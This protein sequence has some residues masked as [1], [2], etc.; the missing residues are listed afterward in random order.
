MW[1]AFLTL[2]RKSVDKPP[3][4]GGRK[5][6]DSIPNIGPRESVCVELLDVVHCENVVRQIRDCIS[7]S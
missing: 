1:T 3:R 7:I 4:L 5:S 6:V 2:G